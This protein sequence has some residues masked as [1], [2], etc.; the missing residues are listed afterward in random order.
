MFLIRWIR[1]LLSMPFLWAGWLALAFKFPLD[2]PLLKAAWYISRNGRRGHIALQAVHRRQGARAA[3]LQAQSWLQSHPRPELAAFAGLLAV[4]AGN[5]DLAKTCLQQGQQLGKERDGMLE[6]LEFHIISRTGSPDTQAQLAQRFGTRNDLSAVL[7]KLVLIQTLWDD[8]LIGHWDDA[9]AKAGR[10]LA[11]A[12]TPE[13]EAA[14]WALALKRGDQRSAESHL[15]RVKLPTLQRTQYLCLGSAAIGD[16]EQAGKY[17]EE[18]RQAE[19]AMA[20]H[21]EAYMRVREVAV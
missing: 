14:L 21:I 16:K 9:A 3:A 1:E 5:M 11:V 10:L 17:F 7:S 12:D 2:V 6:L 8:M 19:P 13:A 4:D 15:S 18:L 20:Q